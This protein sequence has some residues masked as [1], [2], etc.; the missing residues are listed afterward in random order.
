MLDERARRFL[1]PPLRAAGGRLA[2]WGVTPH[3][4][5]AGGFILGMAGAG[6]AS[7]SWWALA[8]VLWLAS[9]VLDALDGAVAR[10]VGA[11]EV[12]GFLDVV[13]DHGRLER[14]DE[15]SIRFVG[16]PA[17]GT[18][19]IAVHSLFACCRPLRR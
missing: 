8:L 2:R 15:R 7:R 9:R 17:E 12:G 5:T 3:Q 18:E 16:G 14:R 10:V 4:L 1:A 19:T 13:A 11:S 6:A